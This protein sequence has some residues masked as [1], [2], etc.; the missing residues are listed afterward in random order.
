MLRV[1][2][3]GFSKSLPR[4][5]PIVCSLFLGSSLWS[6][7]KPL[8]EA[9]LIFPLEH[10]HNHASCIVE[11]PN[12]DLLVCWFHGSGERTADDVKIEGARKRKGA[13]GWSER[14]TMADTPGYPDTNCC[15][16]IDPQGRLWLFWPTILA[17]RWETA[18]MKYRVSSD[19]HHDGPPTWEVNEVLHVTPGPE[20]EI[21]VSNFI[22]QARS[23]SALPRLNGAAKERAAA[24]FDSMRSRAADKFQRR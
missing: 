16:L 19:Y 1:C 9:E 24:W 22:S 4:L 11:T 20:F 8:Y 23:N 7:E 3:I 21:G 14:F 17:N 18:L 15:L 13:S 6:A 5:L 12:G 10:W 2:K